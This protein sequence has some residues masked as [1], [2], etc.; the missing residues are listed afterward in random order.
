MQVLIIKM[1]LLPE[2]IYSKTIC[3]AN[4]YR[5]E[6]RKSRK[7]QKSWNFICLWQI[8]WNFINYAP[9]RCSQHLHRRLRNK[10]NTKAIETVNEM[11]NFIRAQLFGYSK[12][13][14]N[15][16]KVED[17]PKWFSCFSGHSSGLR[18][19]FHPIVVL[20]M[21][22]NMWPS[23]SKLAFSIIYKDSLWNGHR[24]LQSPIKLYVRCV[25]FDSRTNKQDTKQI[26]INGTK[27]ENVPTC[28]SV[29]I[30]A[31]R[32]RAQTTKDSPETHPIQIE[33]LSFRI[34]I[35]FFASNCFTSTQF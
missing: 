17:D 1:S 6:S 27:N 16:R 4:R 21:Y 28:P 29:F 19:L 25:P 34:F 11:R 24:Y 31:T 18:W 33:F 12:K 2:M 15:N 8:F 14:D 13:V 10:K 35:F 23:N 26:G 32:M 20:R 7:T 3:T 22:T 5:N 9:Q 30:Q